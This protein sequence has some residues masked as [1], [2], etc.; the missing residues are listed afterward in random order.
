MERSAP[1]RQCAFLLVSAGNNDIAEGRIEQAIEKNLTMLQMAKHQYQ[2]PTAIEVMVGLAIE[3]LSTK[4]LRN[5]V[6][7]CDVTEE[8]LRVI[9]N[10][11]AGIEH[12]WSCDLTRFLEHDKLMSKS[13]LSMVYQ[14]NSKGKTRLSRN[15]W[16]QMGA[17]LK[18]QSDANEIEDQEAIDFLK[19]LMYPTYWKKKLI[20]ARTILGWFFMPSTPQKAA[21]IIDASYEKYYAMIDPNFD[22]QQK[23]QDIFQ[24]FTQWDFTKIRLNFRYLTKL[25]ANM[26]EGTYYMLHDLYLRS[27]AE[28]RGTLLIIALRRY[29]NENGR[30]PE[31]LDEV[32]G[33]ASEE[34]FVDPINGDAFVYKLIEEDFMLYSVGKNGINEGGI[35]REVVDPNAAK[36][37]VDPN[38]FKEMLEIELELEPEFIRE[39]IDPNFSEE[40]PDTNVLMEMIDP[41]VLKEMFDPNDYRPKI[42]IE[43]DVLI[44]PPKHPELKE[45]DPD[46]RQQ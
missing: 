23:P 41:N 38:F 43:D 8:R 42:T 17:F 11:L 1:M 13:L 44:W 29:K 27:V 37:P 4:Q 28:Q 22:W 12:D 16:A 14:M 39:M 25:L 18:E 24:Y 32:K 26:A 35:R 33:L 9:E 15:P 3:R 36:E 7:T 45:E 31:G 21:K 46:D 19:S 5:I 10:C 20:K 6:V 2:Q 30:W 34:V 40:I